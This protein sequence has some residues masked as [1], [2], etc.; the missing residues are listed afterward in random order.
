MVASVADGATEVPLRPSALAALDGAIL[1]ISQRVAAIGV[2]SILT[3]AFLTVLDVVLRNFFSRSLYGLGEITVLLIALAV[4]AVIP[5]GMAG[6]VSLTIEILESRVSRGTLHWL[7]AF[8]AALLALFLGLIAWRLGLLGHTAMIRQETTI[9]REIPK[10]PFF[11][12]VSAG[13]AVAT[14]IQVVVTL[15]EIET[16]F[17]TARR[18]AAAA[19]AVLVLVVSLF[20]LLVT[21]TIDPSGLRG[22]APA[23][24]VVL[25]GVVFAVMWIFV[26]MM[27]PLGAVMGFAG[28]VGAAA[29]L[30]TGPALEVLGSETRNY[31]TQEA[32]AVL[33]LFLLMGTFAAV[34]GIGSDIYR[35][36]HVMLG[37]FRGGIAH[38]TI[39]GCACFGAL[40]GSSMATQMTIGRLA[41]PEMRKRGYSPELSAGTIAA[42]GT[43]GQLVPPATALILY[44]VMAQQSVGKLFMATIIPGLLAALL[45]MGTVMV[46]VYF[47]P[48]DAP[49]GDAA[50]WRERVAVVRAC[51]APLLLLT[52]VL[53]GIYGGFFTEIEAGSVGAAGA[54]LLAVARGRLT[55]HTVWA[56]MSESTATIALMYAL[57]FGTLMLSFFFGITH[58]PEF[59]IKAINGLNL[60]PLG[61]V[62][63][64]VLC[65]LI[66]GTAMD[67]WAMMVIT[68]PIF[69]PIVTNVGY[70]PI[71]WGIMTVI[72]MEAGQISPP[73]GLNIFLISSIAPDIP[74]MKV[75]R[76]CWPFFWSTCLKIAILI[77][78]PSLTL[79]LVN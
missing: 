27:V 55:R 14:F 22:F 3:V 79:F 64:L 16:A 53:G 74:V 63:A 59:F 57:L 37:H 67:S 77:A 8:G 25:A 71:W 50:T 15:R 24:P 51:W 18:G 66:L 41:M 75:F 33:P 69:V 46:W 7:K 1:K 48:K 2:L 49:R 78:F 13:L 52:L 43:L 21:G 31:L 58:L 45:Y 62:I 5:A 28:L 54:F 70:D 65:Y 23:N 68:V 29:L 36:A 73:F 10:A 9:M 56:V 26:L 76:G 6:R 20:A 11:F 38:A 72:C 39:A 12:G 34:A 4:S 17:A 42:G 61:V 19:L 32:L 47:H 40:T 44:A 30:G 35:L 60:S